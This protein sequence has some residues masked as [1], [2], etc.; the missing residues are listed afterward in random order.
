MTE[1]GSLPEISLAEVR[2]L[3]AERRWEAL[4][5]RLAG[6]PEERF[7]EEPELAV[8]YSD[9]LWRVG[10]PSRSVA[11]AE[12]AL[13]QL[14]RGSDRILLL[15]LTN[16][17]GIARFELGQAEEAAVAWGELLDRATEW[18]HDEFAAR[19]SNN[20]GVVASV[21]GQRELALTYYERALASYRRLGYVRGIAQT[22]YNL[23]ISYR[24]L[25]FFPE[26]E[27]HYA[28]AT[29]YAEQCG[30][31]DVVALA[32][33]DRG[34]LRVQAGDPRMGKILARRAC[35]RFARMGD[36]VRRAESLRVLAAAS[37]AE[38]SL[39][40]ALGYLEAALASAR[41]HGNRLLH[42][43]V[44]RDRGAV[45]R[46]AGDLPAAIEALTDAGEQFA[47]IG[48]A[49][50]VEAVRSL[51]EEIGRIAMDDPPPR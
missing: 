39:D 17:M 24:E 47:A 13:P 28:A 20:L 42:A 5:Q 29:T 37:N 9:S 35:D 8:R 49:A 50:E 46:R 22:H 26:A 27:S 21:H 43:E 3:A 36:P 41:T 4:A 23:G 25:G 2:S 51:L 14:L 16:V 31:E 12:I 48:A 32:E 45:L 18:G 30:S 44:Q 11:V 19:A 6:V 15:D 38:D 34:L 10:N 40:E 7:A 33:S 1:T